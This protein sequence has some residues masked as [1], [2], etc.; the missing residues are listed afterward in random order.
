MHFDLYDLVTDDLD[1]LPGV[2]CIY[3]AARSC[4]DSYVRGYFAKNVRNI[5][6]YLK[7]PEDDTLKLNI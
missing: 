4:I 1:Y 6:Q 7:C 3:V 5:A 2:V